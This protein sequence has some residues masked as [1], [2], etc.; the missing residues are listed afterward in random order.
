MRMGKLPE[1]ILKR[2]VLKQIRTEQNPIEKNAGVGCDA[3]ICVIHGNPQNIAATNAVIEGTS[4]A[5]LYFGVYRAVNGLW[6][7]G[8]VP[9]WMTVTLMLPEDFSEQQLRACMKELNEC[10]KECQVEVIGGHTQTMAALTTPLVNLHVMG[11]PYRVGFPLQSTH[12]KVQAGDAI[13]MSKY[14]AFDATAKWTEEHAEELEKRFYKRFLSEANDLAYAKLENGT[15]V[16]SVEIEA[17]VAMDAD[18]V[19]MHDIGQGGIFAALWELGERELCG[20]DVQLKLIPVCQETIELCEFFG[21][22][23][24]HM[25]SCGALLMVAHDGEA[26]IRE[27]KAGGLA[28]VIVGHVTEKKEKVIRNGEEIRYMDLPKADESEIF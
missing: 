27:L 17:K 19:A 15:P 11:K 13:V 22:N 2:S 9:K 1:T 26:L 14:L 10:C 20:I 12:H 7:A 16:A 8:F 6:A 24:Y 4:H 5:D 18:V 23:P 25:K 21:K 28:A 3:G